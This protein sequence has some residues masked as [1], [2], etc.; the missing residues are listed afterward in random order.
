MISVYYDKFN[1]IVIN[2]IEFHDM[3]SFVYYNDNREWCIRGIFN[4]NNLVNNGYGKVYD[5]QKSNNIIHEAFESI[6]NKFKKI[7]NDMIIRDIIE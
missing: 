5:E 6:S 4:V 3:Y 1:N 7:S 2:V